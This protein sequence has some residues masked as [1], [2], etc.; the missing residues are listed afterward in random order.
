LLQIA[1]Y[2]AFAVI[3]TCRRSN[4]VLDHLVDQ[5]VLVADPPLT[6]PDHPRR[7][8][9]ERGPRPINRSTASG[10][11]GRS[12]AITSRRNDRWMP[13]AACAC[14]PS[15][16][17]VGPAPSREPLCSR[18]SRV[19]GRPGCGPRRPRPGLTTRRRVLVDDLISSST[20]MTARVHPLGLSPPLGP[21]ARRTHTPRGI[22]GQPRLRCADRLGEPFAVQIRLGD[23][24]PDPGG[25]L[26][27]FGPFSRGP[28]T[29]QAPFHQ[30]GHPVGAGSSSTPA[31]GI[32]PPDPTGPVRPHAGSVPSPTG[33]RARAPPA[34]PPAARFPPDHPVQRPRCGTSTPPSITPPRPGRASDPRPAGRPA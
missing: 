21:P 15:G 23:R 19:P 16:I 24:P 8:R 27:A 6:D 31:P 10:P 30:P 29:G 1:A 28:G 33:C 12:A 3:A 18:L 13:P 25:H 14:R 32:E 34:Y 17:G 11:T 7:N 4:L 9:L 22:G 2:S 26:V 20:A 5:A